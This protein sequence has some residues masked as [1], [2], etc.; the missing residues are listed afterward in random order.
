MSCLFRDITCIQADGN[1]INHAYVAVEQSKITYVGTEEPPERNWGEII[2][3]RNKLLIPGLV[4]SHT[5][6]PMVLMRG[7]GDDMPLDRWLNDR[8]F[9]FEAKL[10]GEDV[11]WG[12]MLGIA[13]MLASGTVAFTDMYDFCDRIAEAV[14]ESGIKANIGRGYTCFDPTK[15]FKDISAYAETVELLKRFH[16]SCDGRI[17][18][19]VA[20]HAEYTTR[21]DLLADGA[22]LAAQYGVRMH[23]HVSETRKE[24]EEC[25]GR[26]GKTPVQVMKDTGILSRPVT[27]AHCV[28][29]T[30][31]DMDILAASSD[32]TVAHCAKSNLK[33]GS[34]IA[35]VEKMRSKG[36]S[37]AIGTDSAASNNGLD[38][39]EEMRMA[40]YMAK[41]AFLNPEAMKA[42]TVLH[43]AARVGALSQGRQDCGDIQTGYRA[44]MVMLDMDK[45]CMTPC[46]NPLSNL[47][48]AANST[49]VALTMVDGKIL[50]R[51][52][53][54]TTIDIERILYQVRGC[55]H[56]LLL[57]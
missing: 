6:V 57:R 8:I 36:V 9:P 1:V 12:S 3:G 29:L 48:Y 15:K 46:H 27:L 18:I 26:H 39:L 33:L 31:E 5:H 13:E 24:H 43:M 51:S 10:T 40:S 19:D 52:G 34:G 50:Y 20:P 49:T 16:G 54:F 53:E 4:N 42:S 56:N 38:M 25:V 37:V 22:E 2:D 47:V 14:A 7:Y 32:V 35:R 21:P 45:V 28:W 44:D 23:V 11:Y 17:L 41:G 55:V 30:D